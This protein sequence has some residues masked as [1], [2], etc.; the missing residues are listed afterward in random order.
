VIRDARQ[1]LPEILEG[2][3]CIAGAGPAGIVLALEL[4]QR[5]R[6]VVLLEGGGVDS[7]GEAQSS[8]Q[9]EAHGRPYP[10]L[11]SRLRWL[12]GTSN[13]WGGWVKPLD[14]ID[15]EDKPHFPLPGWPFGP[16]ALADGYR[17]AAGW[18]ELDADDFDPASLGQTGADRLLPLPPQSGFVHRLF[19]FSP[20]TRFGSR[21]RDALE[22]SELIE[23]QLYLNAVSLE[24][25]EDQVRTLVARTM[26]GD[27][28]RVRARHFVLAMG[29][30]ENARF[31]LNQDRVPGNQADLVGRCFMDH[32]GFTPGAMLARESL[33]YERGSLAGQDTM[34]VMA[35]S[36]DAVLTEGFRNCCFLLSID[37]P[38]PILPGDYWNSPLL[39][40]TAGSTQRVGMINEP[41]PHPDS[42]ISLLDE[43]DALGLR[44][45]RLHWHLPPEEFQP[46]LA[47]FERWSRELA[48][49]GLA[50]IRQ[51]RDQY[52]PL[53][54]HVGIGYHHMGTTRMSADPAFGV[55]DPDGRCW[56]RDNLYVVG[57]S[58]FPHVGYSNPT[59]TIVALANRLADH[60]ASRLE[61]AA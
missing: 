23:C 59:L 40:D 46:V 1:Q 60:L 47:L 13:H 34:I 50:R 52:P 9:G 54:Q 7:P 37:A 25:G 24:Q 2:E 55:V 42:R 56:D 11:G 20:P 8:Y 10:L 53:D 38:D 3:V 5:G 21:Y 58:L 27:E 33:G 30:I 31:L 19:R 26:D 28:C 36:R 12:G 41:L 17:A 22:Q 35:P 29:G 4:A 49:A 51:L 14:D 32:F 48:S 39:G 18:C 16:G 45:T 6:K 44:R 57:S 43:R 15:Y 61:R